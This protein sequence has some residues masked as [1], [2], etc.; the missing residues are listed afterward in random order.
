M[1]ELIRMSV[2]MEPE[3]HERLD[4]MLQTSSAENRSE[5]IR[6][7]IRDQLVAREWDADDEIL[8]TITYIYDHSARE[9]SRKLTGLQHRDHDRILVTT[10]LHLDHHL[11][12][13][14]VVARG[15][16]SQVRDIADRIGRQ[17]GVLHT[18]LAMS[19]TGAQLKG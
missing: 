6:D 12:A 10:H 15:T 3:L 18:A 4:A 14:V 9:L 16:A 1:A 2:S 5:F 8:G 7:L 11:C 19:S 13:E 17:K